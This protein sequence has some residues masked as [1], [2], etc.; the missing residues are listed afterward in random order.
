MGLEAGDMLAFR[1][2]AL[3]GSW[4]ALVGLF[5]SGTTLVSCS[6]EHT[7]SGSNATI[8]ATRSSDSSE[9]SRSGAATDESS[10]GP[11]SNA[12]EQTGAPSR[13]ADPQVNT[14]GPVD[15]NGAVDSSAVDSNAT[16]A[17]QDDTGALANGRGSWW[18]LSAASETREEIRL[19]H[20]QDGQLTEN[21]LI[22][23]AGGTVPRTDWS[24]GENHYYLFTD[25]SAGDEV[26]GK[27]VLVDITTSPPTVTALAQSSF[28]GEEYFTG[29]L[30]EN[31]WLQV[32]RHRRPTPVSP[33]AGVDSGLDAGDSSEPPAW[34]PEDFLVDP[35]R[36]DV[37]IPYSPP[38]EDTSLFV[39]AEGRAAVHA[40]VDGVTTLHL[41]RI[42]AAG[43]TVSPV[44][45]AEGTLDLPRWS[46]HAGWVSIADTLE[47]DGAEHTT[48]HVLPGADI[49][50][51]PYS[52]DF[53][54]RLV[55]WEWA[56]TKAL[57]LFEFQSS[58]VSSVYLVDPV[59]R[60]VTPV[61]PPTE[62]DATRPV[63]VNDDAFLFHSTHRTLVESL[64]YL[65]WTNAGVPF[66]PQPVNDELASFTAAGYQSFG[67]NRSE[68][69]LSART[70]TDTSHVYRAQLAPGPSA[71]TLLSGT[72][73]T[74]DVSIDLEHNQMLFAEYREE[75]PADQQ[76]HLHWVNLDNPDPPAALPIYLRASDT[77]CFDGTGNGIMRM[78]GNT[79]ERLSPTQWYPDFRS[80]VAVNL[81]DLFGPGFKVQELYNKDF[82]L[83]F[84]SF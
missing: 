31:G 49:A 20:F 52:A 62:T 66:S 51:E 15:S 73:R 25:F 17:S 56:P 38:E 67:R 16:D 13:T 63:W 41:G 39:D 5:A 45:T 37:L 58:Q 34:E 23:S 83:C 60:S 48:L 71:L 74:L 72:Y 35:Q 64:S 28:A 59:A 12:T 44:L 42:D 24:Y 79:L 36:P 6:R 3:V 26:H 8:D 47:I 77:F 61:Q 57:G 84:F 50:G 43:L 11:A 78:S 55:E 33:D 75:A 4:Y 46:K 21:R 69:F 68:L 81:D 19:V 80:S 76:A 14:S 54:G 27:L 22:S 53:D 2:S 29:S 1:R 70:T 30:L 9:S 65:W 10:D 40:W 7:P 18:L 82:G 32:R